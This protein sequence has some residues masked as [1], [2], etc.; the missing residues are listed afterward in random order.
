MTFVVRYKVESRILFSE[1]TYVFIKNA[2][3]LGS[4]SEVYS[5]LFLN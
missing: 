2:H 5:N 4:K 1:M 3:V